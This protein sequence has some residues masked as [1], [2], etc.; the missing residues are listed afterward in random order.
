MPCDLSQISVIVADD[1]LNMMA[2]VGGI[3]KA[4]GVLNIRSFPDGQSAY[5]ALEGAEADLVVIDWM[6]E[7]L[8]GIE[9]TE[10]YG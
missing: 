6:M 1:N 9:F 8:N 3:L 4:F 7:P 10:K 5:N 2:M